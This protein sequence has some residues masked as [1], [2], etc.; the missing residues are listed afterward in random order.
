MTK[1]WKTEA[2]RNGYRAKDLRAALRE[3]KCP[4]YL[5]PQLRLRDMQQWLLGNIAKDK[6]LARARKLYA[7]HRARRREGF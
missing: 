7:S 5:L 3:M 6:V 2:E 1:S 4:P